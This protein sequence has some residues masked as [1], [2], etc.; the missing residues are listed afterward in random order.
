[1]A[2]HGLSVNEKNEELYFITELMDSDLNVV[3]HKS[4]KALSEAHIKCLTKQ[5]F[6]GLNA[7]HEIGVCH[8][9][10]KPANLLVNQNCHLRIAD[11]G[12]ARYLGSDD[13]ISV[14]EE[15]L[16]AKLTEYVV[17]RWYRAPEVLLSPK[18]R[19]STAIDMWSAGCVMAEMVHRRPLFP[20][21]GCID[22]VK[23]ILSVR[24][25]SDIDELGF[26][27]SRM[28]SLFLNSKCQF[29]GVKLVKLLPALPPPGLN[30]LD[31][32]LALNPDRRPT[33]A[34][35]LSDP[36]LR[37]AISLFDYSDKRMLISPPSPEYFAFE[38]R[39]FDAEQIADL[40]LDEVAEYAQFADGES[41][42]DATD[43]TQLTSSGKICP[44]L[45][46]G[47]QTH[48]PSMM[49]ED[50]LSDKFS[51]FQIFPDGNIRHSIC[52]DALV[53]DSASQASRRRYSCG[54]IVT[55]FNKDNPFGKHNSSTPRHQR[56]KSFRPNSGSNTPSGTSIGTTAELCSE[57]LFEIAEKS[58]LSA[59]S[60]RS[61]FITRKKYSQ[62]KKGRLS[63]IFSSIVPSFLAILG[64]VGPLKKVHPD[65]GK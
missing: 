13:R 32:L 56:R 12:L 7:M 38:R 65:V 22:Q 16:T 36:F 29:P 51:E 15:D 5:L 54:A 20:G 48:Q 26:P 1:M 49:M 6:E 45:D 39:G 23:Q 33:A 28:N 31:G 47:S 61:V 11:F 24:G 30:L 46:A 40:I 55:Q 53:S 60:A 52:S 34:E 27:V 9:D 3:I 4:K 10:I 50:V 64:L 59:K 43:A 25:L 8:R 44:L 62:V 37:D 18:R 41:T 19:Y 35:A 17:T 14:Y 63:T 2:L 57:A 58:P 42:T 21:K